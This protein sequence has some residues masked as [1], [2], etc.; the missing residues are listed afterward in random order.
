[1]E[2]LQTF[3]KKLSWKPSGRLLS[4]GVSPEEDWKIIFISSIILVFVVIILNVYI[5]IKIDKG[6]I[7]GVTKSTEQEELLD[8]S[9]LKETVFYYQNKALKF[10]SFN[11]GDTSI[12]DPSR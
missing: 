5:F 1:M 8:I 4:F 7:F 6:E 9:L 3:F 12:V 11:S 2:K 10:E